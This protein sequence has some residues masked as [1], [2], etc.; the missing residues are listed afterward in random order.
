MNFYK[1][2]LT[3]LLNAILFSLLFHSPKKCVYSPSNTL[4]V[5]DSSPDPVIQTLWYDDGR[6]MLRPT[7]I[8]GPHTLHSIHNSDT[9]FQHTTFYK[10][11][12]TN[13]ARSATNRECFISTVLR[14]LNVTNRLR[15]HHFILVFFLLFYLTKK[16]YRI[17]L[18]PKFISP[19]NVPAA[20]G[21]IFF[22]V[23]I[24]IFYPWLLAHYCFW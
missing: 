13:N 2:G 9:N 5:C 6:G 20:K 19:Q 18:L 4:C 3:L 7:V 22:E 15:N 17:L 12:S 10:N 24:V 23:L 21:N 1:I 11:V 16:V 14:I 8:L